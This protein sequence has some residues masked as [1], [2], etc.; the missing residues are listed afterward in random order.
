[1]RILVTGADGFVGTYLIPRLHEHKHKLFLIGRDLIRMKKAYDFNPICLTFI[2]LQKN[3]L[4]KNITEFS[5]EVVIH[6]AA[7]STASDSYE[8]MERLFTANILFLGKILDSLK[9]S[10]LR[11]FIYTGSCTEYYKGD[12]VLNSTY[13]YS[14]TK[15]AGRSILDY[16]SDIYNFKSIIVTPF[17]V[18]GGGT[19]K[20][21]IIDILYD[22]LDSNYTVDTTFGDQVLDFIHV[23]DLVE[24]FCKIVDKIDII[25]D[26]TNFHAGTGIGTSL[27]QLA[28]L[29]EK[30]SNKKANVN[31]GGIPYRKKDTMYAV[32]D[33]RKQKELLNWQH[34][35]DLKKGVKMYI[36][37]KNLQ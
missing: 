7:Y 27:R 30:I 23:F 13:L 21:K 8:D 9:S 14:A 5:P 15:T 26:K 22:S 3:E 2:D 10:N 28:A 31:W 35:I 16:Y 17:T 19:G 6:L 25:P 4:T 11:C 29:L 18:Y 20:K 33:I 32:A 1:M 37:S 36:D 12:G 34:C 24:L